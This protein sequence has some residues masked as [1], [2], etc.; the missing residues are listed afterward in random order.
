IPVVQYTYAFNDIMDTARLPDNSGR[1]TI[2]DFWATWCSSCIKAFPKME[3]LQD[4]FK[5]RLQVVL[6]NTRNSGDDTIKVN[7]FFKKWQERTG[8]PL[9]LRSVVNDSI[10][11]AMFP[12]NLVPHYVWI[13]SS[14]KVIATTSVEQ[15]TAANRRA[16]RDGVDVA[17]PMKKDQDRDRPLF[18]NTDLPVGQIL[19]Y[20]ILLKGR[21]DG[22]RSGN[23]LHRT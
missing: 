6:V 12:H 1:L 16:V 22:L 15:V 4:E 17:F 5:D 11:D 20:A 18:T 9:Y 13:N 23:R 8:K 2:L 10:L 7:R 14:G 3:T 21:F 19:R